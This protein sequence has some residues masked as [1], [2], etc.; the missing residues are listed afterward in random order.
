MK[1]SFKVRI[2][3]KVVIV[4]IIVS[5]M[6]AIIFY[7]L[8]LTRFFGI[9][10]DIYFAVMLAGASLPGI[11]AI[12]RFIS[13]ELSVEENGLKMSAG[14]IKFS[15]VRKIMISDE[16]RWQRIMKVGDMAVIGNNISAEI[17]NIDSPEKLSGLLQELIEG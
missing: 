6:L 12:K 9:L 15:D 5:I 8:F 16:K 4:S 1:K 11:I 10:F 3:I 2:S 17:R 14:F 13:G 7:M